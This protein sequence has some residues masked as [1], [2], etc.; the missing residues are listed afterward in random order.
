M[1]CNKAR[2]KAKAT[3]LTGG[4]SIIQACFIVKI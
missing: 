1:L 4:N 2:N 3:N